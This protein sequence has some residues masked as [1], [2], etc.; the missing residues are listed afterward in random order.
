MELAHGYRN[1]TRHHKTRIGTGRDR[2]DTQNRDRTRKTRF[3]TK[4]AIKC[5]WTN[6][7]IAASTGQ[8][9]SVPM[10][11]RL[12]NAA[13]AAAARTEQQVVLWYAARSCACGRRCGVY[14]TSASAAAVATGDRPRWRLEKRISRCAFGHCAPRACRHRDRAAVSSRGRPAPHTTT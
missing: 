5:D 4:Y 10:A 2:R 6:N 13:A 11:E 14:E 8:P 9:T 7:A 1:G 3:A 12:R